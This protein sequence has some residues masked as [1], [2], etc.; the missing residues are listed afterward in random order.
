MLLTITERV[1][2]RAIRYVIEQDG[3]RTHMLNSASLDW[4]LEHKLYLTAGQRNEVFMEIGSHG[5]ATLELTPTQVQA[6]S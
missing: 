3:V 5:N 6:A 1:T 4:H 2:T